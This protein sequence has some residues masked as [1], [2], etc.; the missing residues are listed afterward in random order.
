MAANNSTSTQ[1]F[2]GDP[3]RLL[4]SSQRFACRERL[5]KNDID[6][7]DWSYDDP[8]KVVAF[9]CTLQLPPLVLLSEEDE[10]A[11]TTSTNEE[12]STFLF[13][14]REASCGVLRGEEPTVD[15]SKEEE[16]EDECAVDPCFFDPGYT[17]AGKTGFQVWP[18]TRLMVEALLLLLSS[19][20]NNHHPSLA[21]WQHAIRRGIA[22]NESHHQRR[23]RP[24]RV[25]ELGAG[26]GVVGTLLAN[27]GA[28]VLLTDLPSL[29]QKSLQPN[30]Q[31]NAAKHHHPTTNEVEETKDPPSWL[32]P[33]PSTDPVPNNDDD[34]DDDND[35]KPLAMGQGWVAATS[36]DWTKSTDQQLTNEQCDVDVII[37]SDCVWLVSMLDGLLSTVASICQR[38]TRPPIFLMSFQRRDPANGNPDNA[39]FT[40]VDRVLAEVMA[41][42][43]TVD[44]LAW[45]PV[46]YHD[47]NHTE[48][49]KKN[50]A[51]NTKEV[52]L[53]EI[54]TLPP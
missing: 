15:S 24:L 22:N 23:R 14:C 46:V 43:W 42:G 2:R 3:S 16:E 53:F 8:T 1:N 52:F 18:G 48:D 10:R 35:T 17:C 27:A 19:A 29:V 31:R 26:V 28:H 44:C 33:R 9:E 21:H 36:L 32:L 50:G 40:T 49:D 45:H 25:L 34:N 41:R 38:A 5:V 47:T 6:D 11:T 30:L 51:T 54:K 12:T 13:Y 39:M 37:A 4:P 20:E 7:K